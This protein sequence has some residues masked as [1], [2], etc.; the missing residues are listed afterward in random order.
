M[1]KMRALYDMSRTMWSSFIM[2]LIAY[3]FVVIKIN[4]QSISIKTFSINIVTFAVIIFLL[5]NKMK[6]E[7]RYKIRM[8]MGVY[9]NLVDLEKESHGEKE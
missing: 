7:L 9:E 8:T 6:K 3:I 1:E 2:L 5:Y 4:T